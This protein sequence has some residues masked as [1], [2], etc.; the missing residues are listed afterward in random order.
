M[1]RLAALLLFFAPLLPLTPAHAALPLGSVSP[2]EFRAA[3]TGQTKRDVQHTWSSSGQ[4]VRQWWALGTMWRLK[5]Y[6]STWGFGTWVWATYR[7]D[8]T[9]D[10]PVWRLTDLQWCNGRDIAR[11]NTLPTPGTYDCYARPTA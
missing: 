8:V 7:H 2:H 5:S 3:H 9:P 11:T 1:R 6:D 4:L 10:G